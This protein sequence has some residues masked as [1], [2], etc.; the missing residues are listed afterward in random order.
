MNDCVIV[1]SLKRK[2]IY[3]SYTYIMAFNSIIFQK[4]NGVDASSYMSMYGF[5]Q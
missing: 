1:V 4:Q 5:Q 2:T 3:E